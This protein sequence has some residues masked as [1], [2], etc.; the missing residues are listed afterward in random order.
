MFEL[1]PLV[2]AG[3][4]DP[5]GIISRIRDF[6]TPIFL[7]IVGVVSINFLIKRQMTQLIQFVGIAVIVGIL[8][9]SPEIIKSFADFGSGIFTGN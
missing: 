1:I 4:I 7:L 6:I 9:Y 5:D 8:L 3:A 2:L